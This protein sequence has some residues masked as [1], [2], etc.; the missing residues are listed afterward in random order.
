MKDGHIEAFLNDDVIGNP[1]FVDIAHAR[2]IRILSM[3]P[4]VVEQMVALYG[5]SPATIPANSY[6]GQTEDVASTA[7]HFVFFTH[8]DASE[9]LV[10]AMT[11]L[12]FENKS[13]LVAAHAIFKALD[14]AMGPRNFPIPLHPGALKYYREV[15]VI[16]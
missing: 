14:V 8:K 9:D 13:D 11:K 4:E 16:E 3:T 15:G 1:V 2:D 10:Y 5:Y 6:E 7:Q 12:T